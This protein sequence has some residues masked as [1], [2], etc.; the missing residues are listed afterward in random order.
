ME[1]IRCASC[2]ALLFRA[3][4]RAVAGTIEIKC[5]RCGTI[6]IMRPTEPSH[7]RP[8]RR[9]GGGGAHGHRAHTSGRRVAARSAPPRLR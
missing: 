5:R 7:E 1:S 4:A 3:T 9:D 8:E 6:N 2:Q